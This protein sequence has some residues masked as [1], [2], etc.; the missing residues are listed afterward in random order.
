MTYI[1]IRYKKLGGHIHCRLFTSQV[2]DGTYAN[3]G[4]LCF[5]ENEWSDIRDKLSRAEFIDDEVKP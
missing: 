4:E 3:C 1:R 5:D 2:A